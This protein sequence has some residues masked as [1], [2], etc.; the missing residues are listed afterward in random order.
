MKSS[1]AGQQETKEFEA[2]PE[3]K[4]GFTY[5]LHFGKQARHRHRYWYPDASLA[6][7]DSGTYCPISF[8]SE[9][10]ALGKNDPVT[11]G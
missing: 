5:E 2:L 4:G 1:L 10:S 3:P 8:K 7:G 11:L 6:A 9:S